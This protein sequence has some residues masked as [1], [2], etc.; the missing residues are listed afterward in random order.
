MCFEAKRLFK[1][2]LGPVLYAVEVLPLPRAA[3]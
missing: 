3:K 2:A 1:L